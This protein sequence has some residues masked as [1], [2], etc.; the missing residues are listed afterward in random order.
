MK[1]VAIYL[2]ITIVFFCGSADVVKARPILHVLSVETAPD[3]QLVILLAGSDSVYAYMTG[4]LKAGK[5]YNFK[6]LK[7]MLKGKQ[8]DKS[9][10][11]LLRPS[12]NCKYKGTVDLLDIMKSTGMA[13]YALVDISKEEEAYLTMIYPTVR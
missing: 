3:P 7:D 4:D 11:V 2:A 1:T 6:E 10:S 5:K 13:R 12:N 8:E 9:F